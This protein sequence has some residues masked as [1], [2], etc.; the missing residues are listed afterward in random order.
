MGFILSEQIY[1]QDLA[2][3]KDFIEYE[4]FGTLGFRNATL[5]CLIEIFIAK[6]EMTPEVN[7]FY[8]FTF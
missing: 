6:L 8:E 4:Q 7:I 3:W 1:C 2:N 5:A